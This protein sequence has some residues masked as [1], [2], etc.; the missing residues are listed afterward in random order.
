MKVYLFDNFVYFYLRVLRRLWSV[1]CKI[2]TNQPGLRINSPDETADLISFHLESNKPCMIARF[3]SNELNIYLNYLSISNEKHS[4]LNFI[5][6]KE[7]EWF[8]N[9][10]MINLFRDT[11]GFFP[12]DEKYLLRYGEL[13]KRDIQDLDVLASWIE[14]EDI[15]KNQLNGVERIFLRHLEPF[16]GVENWCSVLVNKKVLV[17]HPFD[18]EIHVQYKIK[19]LLFDK[20]ILPDFT[21]ITYKPVLSLAQ[22]ETPFNNWF[23]ALDFM[24]SEID[25]I[26]FDVA[27][28]GAGAYGFHLAAHVKR[29]GRK[30]VHIGGALQLLFGIRGKRWE[31]PNYGVKEW[32]IPVGAYSNLMNQH[33]I[34]PGEHNK[35]TKANLVEGACYW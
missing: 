27:L 10:G 24:K 35:P 7:L 32:G 4:Y 18:Q 8:W 28:I 33:W 2:K 17:I 30:A 9:P 26:D 12:I 11:A 13:I 21:L 23:E 19:D 25:Q 1:L 6:G 29:S 5:R 15:I 20:S 14:N 34:R 22:N 31:D 16:W 3:G